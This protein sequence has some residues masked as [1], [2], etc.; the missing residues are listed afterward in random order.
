MIMKSLLFI[1]MRL[2][3]CLGKKGNDLINVQ[4]GKST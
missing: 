4:K 1:K 2:S 3:Y